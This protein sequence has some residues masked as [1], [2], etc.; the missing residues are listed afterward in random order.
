MIHEMD[1]HLSPAVW[2]KISPTG[3]VV[4][5]KHGCSMLVSDFHDTNMFPYSP[6]SS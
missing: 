5:R 6:N 2:M 3:N 1:M 4:V